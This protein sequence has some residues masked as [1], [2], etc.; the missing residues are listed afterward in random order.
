MEP[1][2][3][4]FIDIEEAEILTEERSSKN[5]EY[6]VTNTKPDIESLE[7]TTY[8]L[9]SIEMVKRFLD[10]TDYQWFAD[11]SKEYIE[12]IKPELNNS[13]LTQPIGIMSIVSTSDPDPIKEL[14]K[15]NKENE[16]KIKRQFNCSENDFQMTIMKIN[17]ILTDNRKKN[18]VDVLTIMKSIRSHNI[19]S[20]VYRLA[21]NSVESGGEKIL[22]WERTVYNKR[23]IKSYNL[24]DFEKVAVDAENLKRGCCMNTENVREISEFIENA[25]SRFILVELEKRLIEYERDALEKKKTI[26]RGIFSFMR[27]EEKVVKHDGKYVLTLVESSI[28]RYSDLLFRLKVYD[29]AAAEYKLLFN[30]TQKKCIKTASAFL[31]LHIYALLCSINYDNYKKPIKELESMMSLLYDY[32][33]QLAEKQR[34]ARISFLLVYISEMKFNYE[35][36]QPT[37]LLG[38][39]DDLQHYFQRDDRL[40]ES[41][42]MFAAL[43][44]LRARLL[45]FEKPPQFRKYSYR[46]IV[47]SYRYTEL[48]LDDYALSAALLA[49]GYYE[50]HLDGNWG[51]V[52]DFVY[53]PLLGKLSYSKK[54]FQTAL[55]CFINW[56][57]NAKSCKEDQKEGR[58]AIARIKNIIELVAQSN[59]KQ[60]STKNLYDQI[61]AE[62]HQNL[63]LISCGEYDIL[64][65]EDFYNDK[66]GRAPL[67]LLLSNVSYSIKDSSKNQELKKIIEHFTEKDWGINPRHMAFQDVITSENVSQKKVMLNMTS[68]TVRL[69]EEFVLRMKLKNNYRVPIEETILKNFRFE[70]SFKEGNPEKAFLSAADLVPPEKVDEILQINVLDTKL[71]PFDETWLTI[72]I[73]PLKIGM[74]RLENLLWEEFG[75]LRRQSLYSPPSKFT[76]FK[77]QEPSGKI[78]QVVDGIKDNIL[79]GEIQKGSLVIINSVDK[80]INKISLFSS[81]PSQTG[82]ARKKIGEL[83]GNETQRIDQNLI[84]DTIK[85]SKN[86]LTLL[87]LYQTEDACWRYS[88][89]KFKQ[90][91]DRS[92]KMKCNVEQPT[93]DERLICQDILHFKDPHFIKEN[94]I[95]NQVVV[96][97]KK[98][99]QEKKQKIIDKNNSL[100]YYLSLKRKVALR[101]LSTVGQPRKKIKHTFDLFQDDEEASS[102]EYDSVPGVQ[103]EANNKINKDTKTAIDELELLKSSLTLNTMLNNDM[104]T[105]DVILHILNSDRRKKSKL[106]FEKIEQNDNI[107]ICVLWDYYQPNIEKESQTS[108]ISG[109]TAQTDVYIDRLYMY[110]EKL[111]EIK[112]SIQN[113]EKI[114]HN[115][116]QNSTCHLEIE[117]SVLAANINGEIQIRMLNP[118]EKV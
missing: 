70:I 50:S 81:D 90:N 1:I 62:I 86:G 115:F 109:V 30:E 31:E 75:I 61:M 35:D 42:F 16:K 95:I 56:I 93:S 9:S 58:K 2:H 6:V 39:I 118:Y 72:N 21:I 32:A 59:P 84:C 3:I 38:H 27:K 85:V 78:S 89:Y 100:Q 22:D 57:E 76:M 60:V 5:I 107:D 54:R 64:I 23:V 24:S 66:N 67:D 116:Q 97:S 33:I 36:K 12:S 65:A 83:D 71:A 8:D 46:T 117:I 110:K 52:I 96:L 44:E 101:K 51:M 25:M 40:F 26:K 111:V 74:I 105:E 37:V 108:K 4:K 88:M 91:S 77:I 103:P 73:T 45:L 82:F 48:R 106:G 98:W 34:F 29:M 79:T 112:F 18:D 10:K 80:K 104:F 113:Q 43:E 11:I 15:L 14:Q 17:V 94:L 20:Y 99:A 68:R 13:M 49:R 28:R 55:K 19:D 63:K 114:Y 69:G 92:F 53:G 7:K 87:A 41:R 102:E 47:A